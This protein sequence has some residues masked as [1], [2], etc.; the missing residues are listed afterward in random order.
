M[1][2]DS[3]AIRARGLLG[4]RLEAGRYWR[5]PLAEVAAVAKVE[6]LLPAWRAKGWKFGIVCEAKSVFLF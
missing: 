4:L 2:G 3:N 1:T 6:A 5:R